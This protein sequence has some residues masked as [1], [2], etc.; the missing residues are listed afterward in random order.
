MKKLCL[1]LLISLPLSSLSPAFGMDGHESVPDQLERIHNHNMSNQ[2]LSIDQKD[3]ERAAKCSIERCFKYR[4]C[5]RIERNFA[6]EYTNCLNCKV[7][8]YFYNWYQ[9]DGFVSNRTLAKRK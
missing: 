4:S 7:F 6:R 1:T 8:E 9:G 2:D 5:D 3:T